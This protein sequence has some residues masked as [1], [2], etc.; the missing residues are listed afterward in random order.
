MKILTLIL[1]IVALGFLSSVSAQVL[2]FDTKFNQSGTAVQITMNL[3]N[4]DDVTSITAQLFLPEGVTIAGADKITAGAAITT[5][6]WDEWEEVYVPSYTHTLESQNNGDHWTILVFS[7]SLEKIPSGAIVK[8]TASIDKTIFKNGN[9]VLKG[10]NGSDADRNG[11]EYGD[12]TIMYVGANGYST[13]SASENVKIT[14]ASAF[15]GKVAGSKVALEEY[16][17]G[18]VP[19]NT[20]M[21]L[22]SAESGYKIIAT[23]TDEIPT[24]LDTDLEASDGVHDINGDYVLA[25]STEGTQFYQFDGSYVLP[26][27]KAYIPGSKASGARLMVSDNESGI[28]SVVTGQKDL[29]YNLQGQKLNEAK[30]GINVVN[31]KKVLY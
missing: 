17:D 25:T 1:S 6:I 26:V 22:K 31:G 5:Q 11:Y 30:K 23:V 4:S 28:S 16:A 3:D 24:V 13:F 18:V 29:I 9:F 2:S 21:V 7:T 12:E 20:G 8:I 14:G 10:M 15:A 19:A 27:G